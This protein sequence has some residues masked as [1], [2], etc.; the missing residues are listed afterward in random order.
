MSHQRPESSAITTP[1]SSRA[2]TRPSRLGWLSGAALLALVL[3]LVS[4]S[5]AAADDFDWRQL[6]Y[7][8]FEQGA[9]NWSGDGGWSVQPEG[10][11]NHVLA[12]SGPARA[13][14]EFPAPWRDH[15][16]LL[17]IGALEGSLTIALRQSQDREYQVVV[18]AERLSL[19]R[20]V[21]GR[22]PVELAS[23]WLNS[24]L[25]G[26]HTLMI[27][28]FEDHLMVAIDSRDVIDIVDLAPLAEGGLELS[29][30]PHASA[31][32]DDVWITGRLPLPVSPPDPSLI[33]LG[34]VQAGGAVQVVGAGGSVPPGATVYLANVQTLDF[35]TAAAGQDGSWR[36]QI[37]A[38]GCSTIQI[39]YGYPGARPF[40][41][42]IGLEGSP[43]LLLTVPLPTGGS[44][45]PFAIGQ[46][47]NG[48]HWVARGILGR[49]AYL[50]GEALT[51]ALHV[52][53][54]S[55]RAS[56][57]ASEDMRFDLD[58][59]LQ[60]LFDHEGNQIPAIRNLASAL[61]TPS[62]LPVEAEI[63]VA[64][65]WIAHVSVVGGAAIR[66]GSVLTITLPL[67]V[68]IP[69]ELPAGTYSL[70][71]VISMMV[72]DGSH[73]TASDILEW[74][75][76]F[77]ML[78][79]QDP[80]RAYPWPLLPPI[81]VGA[82]GP[83]RITWALLSDMASNSERGARALDDTH[84]SL[85]PRTAFPTNTF[86]VPRLDA[87]TGLPVAYALQPS[88]PLT[89]W[90]FRTLYQRVLV[91]PPSVPLAYPGG[92]LRVQVTDPA[93]ET[94]D[95]GSASFRAGLN[96]LVT[97]RPGQAS[98]GQVHRSLVT[99]FG[100]PGPSDYYQA[101]TGS[102]Q[103]ILKF[104]AYG[105]HTI[106]MQGEM[107]DLWGN[108]YLA[109]GTY[110]IWVA[111]Q[112]DLEL[113]TLVGTPFEVG[114][115]LSPIVRTQPAVPAEISIETS[116]YINSSASN[117]RR[118]RVTG[119]ANRFGYFCPGNRVPAITMSSP[120]EYDMRITAQY[121]DA[122][123]E[124]WMG[125]VRGAG[126]VET[127]GTQLR[128]HGERGIRSFAAVKR[129]LWFAEGREG[130]VVP[131][132]TDGLYE[133]H[134]LGG[135]LH[136]PYP[137]M[138][139]DLMWLVD[140]E[141][142]NSIFPTITLQDVGGQIADLM[143]ARVPELRSGAYFHGQFPDQLLP[144]DRRAI[145]EL[146][147]VTT[148]TLGRKTGANY[149]WPAGQFPAHADQIAYFY[150]SN[151]RPGVLVAQQVSE[152]GLGNAYWFA[153]DNYNLQYGQ[154]RN[155]DLAPDFKLNFGGGVFRDL[156]HGANEY[157]IYASADVYIESGEAQG[158][159]IMPPFQGAAGGPDGGPIMTLKGRPVDLFVHPTGVRPGSILEV[160]DTFSFAAQIVP[161]LDSRLAVTVTLPSGASR[162]IR[163]QANKIGFFYDPTQ[164]FVVTEAGRYLVQVRGWHEGATSAGPMYPPYPEGDMLGSEAGSFCVY[165]VSHPWP[166]AAAIPEDSL[167]RP[168]E[169]LQ[170]A[171]SVPSIWHDAR[172]WYTIAMSGF[173]LDQGQ[174]GVDQGAF[175]YRYDPVALHQAFPNLDIE[176]ISEHRT[177]R[178]WTEPEAVDTIQLS[179]YAEGETNGRI[180]QRARAITLQ[181]MRLLVPN[182][183]R[184][185]PLP[186]VMKG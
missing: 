18:G 54:E 83:A 154:G 15:R 76:D 34:K 41:E 88:L 166:L 116:L 168:A 170:I 137:Y 48:G 176:I 16:L 62:G 44:G 109:G 22:A 185:K 124:L 10:V 30:G 53:L 20:A 171:G 159:R 65:P 81:T 130:N 6:Y 25:T 45:L 23:T 7:D 138:A 177:F 79:H 17:R 148:T 103:F 104:E 146:P 67:T 92:S 63:E 29:L 105:K 32:V 47:V 43:G 1:R 115:T 108:R 147:L 151:V 97:Y 86:I 3:A 28:L 56:S 135:S 110:E 75:D 174:L 127:P 52:R 13:R 35:A 141:G 69:L 181:G 113:G 26:W 94:T 164:D 87:A 136:L 27:T 61:L 21:A 57:L 150:S 125:V 180:E 186:L 14:L 143:E 163:G 64:D 72:R 178:P 99:S 82:A 46:R 122:H 37:F 66:Q 123:G 70:R 71:P 179:L 4:S 40:F 175:S 98:P 50:P 84:Y 49:G 12:I 91:S 55:S 74:D 126:V 111:H 153:D 165:V 169:P 182:S 96:P 183:I 93:G 156:A 129:P 95:L 31:R 59:A 80:D 51:T 107:R 167:V 139:G 144:I 58:V 77:A 102:D 140:L 36:A 117:V 11:G 5:P 89:S 149:G 90:G 173:L 157:A 161:T 128:A 119:T 112:L 9:A 131:G 118:R 85:A 2:K 73:W 133:E 184:T 120:G 106:T 152:S 33:S 160:G 78:E 121:W 19:L 155:G 60:R 68:T 39:N 158:N 162:I 132:Q 101:W 172:V 100:N 145:G 38:P 24:P 114:D 8:G 134:E 42:S 142:Q